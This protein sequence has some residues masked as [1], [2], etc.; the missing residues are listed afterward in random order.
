MDEVFW[1]NV[2]KRWS[3]ASDNV[4][5][6]KEELARLKGERSF[7][8]NTTYASQRSR[9]NSLSQIP[10]R[11][12]TRD[13]YV[14]LLPSNGRKA[15]DELLDAEAGLSRAKEEYRRL[16]QELATSAERIKALNLENE[17]LSANQSELAKMRKEYEQLRSMQNDLNVLRSENKRYLE[18]IRALERQQQL[19]VGPSNPLLKPPFVISLEQKIETFKQ[20]LEARE[21]DNQ[22]LRSDLKATKERLQRSEESKEVLLSSIVKLQDIARHSTLATLHPISTNIFRSQ[23]TNYSLSSACR[24]KIDEFSDSPPKQKPEEDKIDNSIG[25]PPT[26]IDDITFVERMASKSSFRPVVLSSRRQ[27]TLTALAPVVLDIEDRYLNNAFDREFL[28]VTLRKSH[29][30]R[31]NLHSSG[32]QIITSYLCPTLNHHPWC[33]S[34]PGDHGFI[35]VGLGKDK[36]SYHSAAI[37]NLFVGLPK[38]VMN[39]RRFRYL[40]KY[41]VTRVDPL[42]IDEWAMLSAEFKAV[43]AKL[44]K[45]KTKDARTLEDIITAYENGDL[46]VPCVQL[47][48]VGFDEFFFTTL[49]GQ[50]NAESMVP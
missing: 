46:R 4:L 30:H 42:G 11:E 40:G 28:K 34:R 10:A 50:K 1:A 6:L 44:T 21:A 7:Y 8:H 12:L 23:S 45:D 33:P 36:D 3:E 48:C 39:N 37:R 5:K 19:G 29:T 27:K 16:Q 43:Y 32:K 31:V 15:T 26:Q 38:T 14:N 25:N 24:S 20:S 18:K 35:F 41:R 22:I 17:V 13:V 2:V 9:R 47:Q 49:L